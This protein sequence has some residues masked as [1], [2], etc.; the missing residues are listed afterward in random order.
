VK[1]EIIG[2]S[3]EQED[4]VLNVVSPAIVVLAFGKVTSAV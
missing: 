3:G 4:G 1:V 2:G